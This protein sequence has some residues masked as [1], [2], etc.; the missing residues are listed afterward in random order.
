MCSAM[1]REAVAPGDGALRTVMTSPV[2]MIRKSSTSDPS[3]STACAR[4]P[5]GADVTSEPVIQ[6]R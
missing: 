6:G 2:R 4:T 5:A 3:A 1:A